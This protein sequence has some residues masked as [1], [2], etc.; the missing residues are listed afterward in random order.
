MS[1]KRAHNNAGIALGFCGGMLIL[2]AT[3][4]G[5]AIGF[6]VG[7]I[8]SSSLPDQLEFKWH[9]GGGEKFS[10]WGK[11]YKD[12]VR[13]SLIPH[14]TITHWLLL[15][16]ALACF[17]TFQFIENQDAVSAALSGAALSSLLHVVMDSRTKDGV[18]W[19][20]P[21]KRTSGMV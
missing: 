18:P 20:H 16:L 11:K 5:G 21:Y 13:H 4:I 8:L 1:S 9:T 7:A 12:G 6:F 15:W 2:M 17:A 10:L 19:F 14:R 3:D